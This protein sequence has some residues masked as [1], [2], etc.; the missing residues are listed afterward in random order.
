MLKSGHGMSE[1]SHVGYVFIIAVTR[2]SQFLGWNLLTL[3][4][5][6]CFMPTPASEM[7]HCTV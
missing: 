5:A 2:S 4:Y 1:V 6:E 3:W 7:M